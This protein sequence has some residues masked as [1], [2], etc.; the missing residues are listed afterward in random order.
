VPIN[1]I[2]AVATAILVGGGQSAEAGL[3]GMPSMLGQM[4]KRISFGNF[5]LA[6]MALTQ[7]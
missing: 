3:I 7:F 6:P 4:V 2:V 5:T 1:W